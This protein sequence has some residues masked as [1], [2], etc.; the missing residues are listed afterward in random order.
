MLALAGSER[1]D[2]ISKYENE[3]GET[4][5]A[6]ALIESSDKGCKQVVELLIGAKADVN[7][8]NKVSLHDC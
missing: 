5:Q 1:V 2:D 7:K 3:D 6:T 8:C 4:C